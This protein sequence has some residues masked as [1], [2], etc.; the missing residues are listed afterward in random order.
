MPEYKVNDAAVQHAR[1]LIDDGHVDRET[2][3]SKAAPSTDGENKV[4]DKDGY[5]GYGRWHLGIEKGASEETKGRFGFPFGDFQ[6]V[7]RA[8]LIHAKQRASQNEHD[9]IAKAADEL[10]QRLDDKAS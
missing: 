1:T 3:W 8:A 2:E 10:L 7:N 4:I 6:N 5:D 9:D